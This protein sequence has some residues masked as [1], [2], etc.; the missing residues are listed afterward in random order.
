MC[1]LLVIKSFL[2]PSQPHKLWVKE[3]N[4]SPLLPEQM[5]KCIKLTGLTSDQM[6]PLNNKQLPTCMMRASLSCSCCCFC[7]SMAIFSSSL[8]CISALRA[9]CW[10]RL[11]WVALLLWSS[12]ISLDTMTE[13]VRITEMLLRDTFSSTPTQ[14][15]ILSSHPQ[16]NL[17]YL[18]PPHPPPFPLPLSTKESFLSSNPIWISSI[19]L[20]RKESM[21]S[22]Y[23]LQY[24]Q[25][26]PV[27][28]FSPVPLRQKNLS[29]PLLLKNIPNPKT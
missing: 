25:T 7:C 14:W 21:L 23:T 4:P 18:P 15:T 19:S 10:A 24:P 17:F 11:S 27:Y 6:L 29:Y 22:S 2:M 26:K 9:A 28:T 20:P 12:A 8:T 3:L 5:K 13:A 1:M 16:Q